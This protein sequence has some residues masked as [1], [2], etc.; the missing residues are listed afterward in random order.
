MYL[1]ADFTW[2]NWLTFWTYAVL[3]KHNEIT[4]YQKDYVLNT[5]QCH[6][7]LHYWLKNNIMLHTIDYRLYVTIYVRGQIIATKL[8]GCLEEGVESWI[9]CLVSFT[10]SS[11]L[12]RSIKCIWIWIKLMYEL[13]LSMYM[14]AISWNNSTICPL[15]STKKPVT[16]M[17]TYPWKCTVLHC[18]HLASAWAIIKVSGHQHQ[19][20]PGVSQVVTM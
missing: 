16:T 10:R 2:L 9:I 4:V 15:H 14:A 6:N 3:T 18:N 11:Q 13:P 5:F 12:H 7:A 20:F 1:W 17:L 8:F 19:W